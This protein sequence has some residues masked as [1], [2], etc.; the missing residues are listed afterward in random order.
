MGEVRRKFKFL[1][2]KPFSPNL[3]AEVYGVDLSSPLTESQFNEIRAAFLDYQV[4]FLKVSPK[5]LLGNILSLESAL[6]NY[7]CIQQRR[8]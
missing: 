5:L 8:R 2:V 6:G 3:G 4:L 1:D 7:M